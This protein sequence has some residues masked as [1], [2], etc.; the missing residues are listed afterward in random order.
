M[1]KTLKNRGTTGVLLAKD[2]TLLIRNNL[3]TCQHRR[4]DALDYKPNI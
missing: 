2:Q 4:W 1:L 3:T